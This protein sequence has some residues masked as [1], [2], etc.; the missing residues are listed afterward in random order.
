LKRIQGRKSPAVEEAM[1]PSAMDRSCSSSSKSPGTMEKLAVPKCDTEVAARSPEAAIDSTGTSPS[2]RSA[3]SSK[4]LDSSSANSTAGSSDVNPSGKEHHRPQGSDNGTAVKD[5]KT[6]NTIA[7]VKKKPRKKTL[8]DGAPVPKFQKKPNKKLFRDD[9]ATAKLRK[10]RSSSSS[11]SSITDLSNDSSSSNTDRKKISNAQE[12][13][14]LERFWED[15]TKSSKDDTIVLEDGATVPKLRGWKSSKKLFDEKPVKNSTRHGRDNATN[16]EGSARQLRNPT[17]ERGAAIPRKMPKSKRTT[18]KSA[19]REKKQSKEFHSYPKK[20]VSSCDSTGDVTNKRSNKVEASSTTSTK[21]RE[22]KKKRQEASAGRAMVETKELVPT[23]LP[24]NVTSK[25]TTASRK[26]AQ[27]QESR[28]NGKSKSRKG[29]NK[30]ASSNSNEEKTKARSGTAVEISHQCG[31]SK[32]GTR[33]KIRKREKLEK[34]I[35]NGAAPD[36]RA[37]LSNSKESLGSSSSAKPR[38]SKRNSSST[39]DLGQS[40]AS[41]SYNT[42]ARDDDEITESTDASAGTQ[43]DDG[44]GWLSNFGKEIVALIM[45]DGTVDEERGSV[46]VMVVM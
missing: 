7:I 39:Y 40:V 13:I 29:S 35:P 21:T 11:S 22:Q 24:D 34:S 45:D 15:G 26:S 2:V 3:K 33:K 18:R 23:R 37:A 43:R 20:A 8:G 36:N 32:S 14:P 28:K 10:K 25:E 19:S 12:T 27:T 9:V 6:G 30:V 41:N 31:K 5:D 42:D 1:L 4:S 44:G 38:S 46:G 16:T 17:V